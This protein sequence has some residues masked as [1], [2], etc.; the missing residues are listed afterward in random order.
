MAVD[1]ALQIGTVGGA[2]AAG[3]IAGSLFLPGIGTFLGFLAGAIVGLITVG[4]MQQQDAEAERLRQQAENLDILNEPGGYYDQIQQALQTELDD[5]EA[6]REAAATNLSMTLN[7]LEG[8][9]DVS[10]LQT[11]AQVAGQAVQGLETARTGEE[12]KGQIGA[13][14]GAGGVSVESGSVLKMAASV[15]KAVGRRVAVAN[16]G[17][18]VARAEGAYTQQ[19]I[20]NNMLRAELNY[21]DTIRAQDTREAQATAQQTL[22]EYN[23][24][25]SEDDQAYMQTQAEWMQGTGMALTALGG[26]MDAASAGYGIAQNVSK[27]PSATPQTTSFTPTNSRSYLNNSGFVAAVPELQFGGSGGY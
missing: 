20:R 13:A 21:A 2:A 11:A 23:R 16:L 22:T 15:S 4:E 24:A 7:E 5:I 19:V 10:K 3:A 25:T 6:D 1:P 18:G 27:L 8:Q 9:A 14:A 17:I 12:T 26:I